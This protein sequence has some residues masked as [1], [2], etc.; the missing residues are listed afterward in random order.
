MNTTTTMKTSRLTLGL[1]LL[2]LLPQAGHCFYNPS[3]GRWLSRDPIEERGG[4]DLYALASNNPVNRIDLLGMLDPKTFWNTWDSMKRQNWF[5]DFKKD[6]G[7]SIRRYARQH[8]IPKALL[9]AII[10][11]EQID[12]SLKYRI[13]ELAG[14]GQSLGPAQIRVDTAIRYNLL[15]QVDPND[16][17]DISLGAQDG[18]AFVPGDIYYRQALRN[19]L[20]NSD[21]NIQAAARLMSQYLK[22]MCQQA[23]DGQMSLGFRLRIASGCKV[24]DFC[25]RKK[26]CQESYEAKVP[27]CLISAMAAA[28]NNGI[29][30][31]QV[32]NPLAES[33]GAVGHADFAEDLVGVFDG[34]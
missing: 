30:I 6:Y 2:L 32:K 24:P 7:D 28:W 31:T 23:K 12:Y 18:T 10:A 33:P 29:G 8:C 20:N 17:P 9:A 34:L 5:D 4:R 25:C 26:S 22:T 14:L 19:Q 1:M 11:N 27:A 13:G 21:S 3:T 16:Y 15:P